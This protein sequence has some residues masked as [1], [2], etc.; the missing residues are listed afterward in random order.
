MTL[1]KSMIEKIYDFIYY[2]T[3]I[4]VSKTNHFSPVSSSA[5]LLSL[6]LLINAMTLFFLFEIQ[7]SE[8]G[9]YIICGLVFLGSFYI[10]DH[11]NDEKARAIIVK[12]KFVKIKKIW[13]YL[14]DFY[15]DISI[16]LCITSTGA[17]INTILTTLGIIVLLRLLSLFAQ[18]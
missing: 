18:M 10:L 15:P 11:Y 17:S 12:Y 9:F 5:R 14:I 3:Y 6:T 7:F 1:K 4:A 2:R 8:I 13:I 16:L